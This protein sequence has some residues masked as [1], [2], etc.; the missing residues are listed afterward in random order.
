MPTSRSASS[1]QT[2]SQPTHRA[3][4]AP[5]P[6]LGGPAQDVQAGGPAQD[7]Q[8][9]AAPRPDWGTA[10]QQAVNGP[11]S[12]GTLT[13][14]L[15]SSV[16]A[17]AP[18][19][20]GPSAAGLSLQSLTGSARMMHAVQPGAESPANARSWPTGL[21]PQ[22][23]M[24]GVRAVPQTAAQAHTDRGV[25]PKATTPAPLPGSPA[26]PGT[27]GASAGASSGLFFAAAV[28]LGMLILGLP[29]LLGRARIILER[30]RPAPFL[31]LLADPG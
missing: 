14:P 13:A 29:Q 15:T 18:R 17:T 28:L 9:G 20:V 16:Q 21:V 27:G 30:G 11:A 8:A 23:G 12:A 4:S 25:S 3:P 26:E 22:T 19:P 7:V 31:S 24:T 1:G 10:P 5:A 2:T 6:V